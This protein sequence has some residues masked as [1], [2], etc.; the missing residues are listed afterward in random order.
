MEYSVVIRTLG[1][2]G[3]KYQQTLNSI[4]SQTIKA[5]EIIIVLTRWLN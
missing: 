3:E 4:T 1:T 5:K 2:A